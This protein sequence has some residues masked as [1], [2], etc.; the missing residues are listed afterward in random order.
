MRNAESGFSGP[1]MSRVRTQKGS[2][3]RGYGNMV[4]FWKVQVNFWNR[5]V[6]KLMELFGK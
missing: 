3:I 4:S 5:L 2:F 1:S 6:S